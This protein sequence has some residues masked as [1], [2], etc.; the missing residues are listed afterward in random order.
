MLA[1]AHL[2]PGPGDNQ[3]PMH[4]TAAQFSCSGEV[5]ATYNDEVSQ[6]RL[7]ISDRGRI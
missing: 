4:I 7:Q 3:R 2:R 1:P 6:H 5:V